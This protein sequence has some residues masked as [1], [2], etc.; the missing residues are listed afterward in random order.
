[1]A[2]HYSKAGWQTTK[3]PSRS[4]II[5]DHLYSL[6]GRALKAQLASEDDNETRISVLLHN[7]CLASDVDS[8]VLQQ[9]FADAKALVAQLPS[10]HLWHAAIDDV[11]QLLRCTRSVHTVTQKKDELMVTIRTLLARLPQALDPVWRIYG[12]KALATAYEYSNDHTTSIEINHQALHAAEACQARHLEASLRHNIAVSYKNWGKWDDALPYFLSSLEIADAADWTYDQVIIRYNLVERYIEIGDLVEAETHAEK[13]LAAAEALP[14]VVWR[15]MATIRLAEVRTHQGLYDAARQLIE[16]GERLY[17]LDARWQ[18]TH[19]MLMTVKCTLAKATGDADALVQHAQSL[20]TLGH[21]IEQNTTVQSALNFL[22]DAYVAQGDYRR[23]FA[24]Q[25]EQHERYKQHVNAEN[26]ERL[27][28]L[29]VQYR[30]RLAEQEREHLT[31]RNQD[32]ERLVNER[33]SELAQLATELKRSLAREEELGYIKSRILDSLDHQFRTPLTV[34]NNSAALLSEYADR[35]GTDKRVELRE[36]IQRSVFY[37]TD[38]L[39]DVGLVEQVEADSVQVAWE[40]W[41]FDRIAAQLQ[42]DLTDELPSIEQVRFV[43]DGDANADVQLDYSL[44]YQIV[45]NLLTNAMKYSLDGSPIVCRL[46]LTTALFIEVED[47]GIGI[48][49]DDL[50]RIWA[51]F[52]RADNAET[53]RGLG[54]GLYIVKQYV[55]LLGGTASAESAGLGHGTTFTVS[56]PQP[57]PAAQSFA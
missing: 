35:L 22:S 24:V 38:M 16:E 26:D 12:L 4:M 29:E 11:C 1:M 20:H 44:L 46:R 42:A 25:V 21:E 41:S 27:Q 36:R 31:N 49:P 50:D 28:R 30:T 53:F 3:R 40:V 52:Y 33:T 19:A 15:L 17:A 14:G 13:M 32:L 43:F 47:S 57:A 10:D 23:A 2:V 48:A 34:I 55:A 7:F 37:L 6:D 18:R 56:L 39:T 8:A 9:Y 54:M 45:S 51:L 5:P